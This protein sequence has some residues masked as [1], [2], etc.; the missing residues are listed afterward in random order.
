ML[1][2]QNGFTECARNDDV[3]ALLTH[4]DR[5]HIG[6][7]VS[8]LYVVLSFLRSCVYSSVCDQLACSST[9]AE[10]LYF[11]WVTLSIFWF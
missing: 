5:K 9:I 2:T 10:N 4:M 1:L 7:N 11:E 3:L 6:S 8:D